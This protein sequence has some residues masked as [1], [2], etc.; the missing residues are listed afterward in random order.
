MDVRFSC[1]RSGKVVSTVVVYC[2]V[3]H[4]HTLSTLTLSPLGLSCFF[5]GILVT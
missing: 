5:G 4:V 3:K 2:S 1:Q